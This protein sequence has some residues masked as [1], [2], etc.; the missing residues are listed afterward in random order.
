VPFFLP[1]GEQSLKKDIE[2][3]GQCPFE[4]VSQILLLQQGKVKTFSQ[5]KAEPPV[6]QDETP[7]PPPPPKRGWDDE[8]DDGLLPGE[9]QNEETFFLTSPEPQ[10][11]QAV[12]FSE[13]PI[14]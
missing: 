4:A 10:S 7:Q 9:Q 12:S 1:S 13:A 8:D 5:D 6:Q 3:K 14:L 11:G 2:R